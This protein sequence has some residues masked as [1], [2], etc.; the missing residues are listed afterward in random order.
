MENVKCIRKT[1]NTLPLSQDLKSKGKG[2]RHK[3]KGS[4]QQRIGSNTGWTEVVGHS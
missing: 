1:Q 2:L 3:I 4:K